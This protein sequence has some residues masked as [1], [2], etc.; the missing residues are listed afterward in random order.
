MFNVQ[1][2]NVKRFA[3][4][5]NKKPSAVHDAYSLFAGENNIF[6]RPEDIPYLTDMECRFLKIP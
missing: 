3:F 4:R 6:R 2:A 5:W 1:L